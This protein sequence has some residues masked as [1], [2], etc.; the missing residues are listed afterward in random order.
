MADG[1]LRRQGIRGNHHFPDFHGSHPGAKGR[2][3][4]GLPRSVKRAHPAGHPYLHYREHPSHPLYPAPDRKSPG[5][6]GAH[7]RAEKNRPLDPGQGR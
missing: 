3:F 7:P 6:N 2:A 5:F 1:S 4:S